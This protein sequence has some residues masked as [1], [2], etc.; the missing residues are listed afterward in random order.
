MFLI[1]SGFLL[2]SGSTTTNTNLSLV[3]PSIAII[4]ASSTAPLT[5][6]AI[7]IRNEFISKVKFRFYNVRDWINVISLL[8]E[9][10][11]KSSMIDR[12]V[13]EKE[14]DELKIYKLYLDK[15]KQVMME[16]QFK[17]ED[18]FGDV[19]RKDSISPVQITKPTIFS[20][21]IVRVLIVV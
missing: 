8:Y 10:T 19:I 9:K 5:S 16:T 11:L 12:K 4:I 21:K 15:R 20:A 1:I 14:S 13:D 2:G 3:N 17:V 18:I 6:L 7:L